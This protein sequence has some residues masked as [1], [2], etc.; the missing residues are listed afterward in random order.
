M[1]NLQQWLDEYGA[2]H[3]NLTN[4]KVHL[5][6]VPLIF[7]SV[8]AFLYLIPLEVSGIRLGDVVLPLVL[9]WYVFLGYKPFFIMAA[10]VIAAVSITIGA[11]VTIGTEGAWILFGSIFV[12]AWIGQFW[13]HKQEGRKPSFFKDLQYLLI[14]PLWVWLGQH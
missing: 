5:I 13:G 2:D 14:G 10:Q 11:L 7:L 8:V 1:K 6:C 12:L 4:Q 3:R 9:F